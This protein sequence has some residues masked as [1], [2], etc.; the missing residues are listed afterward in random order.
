MG[1]I[2]DGIEY[3]TELEGYVTNL[4]NVNDNDFD[5]AQEILF[6]SVSGFRSTIFSTALDILTEGANHPQV[7][8]FA[9]SMLADSPFTAIGIMLSVENEGALQATVTG[10]TSAGITTAIGVTVISPIIASTGL[11]VAGAFAVGALA[12]GIVGYVVDNAVDGIYDYFEGKIT[13]L[14]YDDIS[15]KLIIDTTLENIEDVKTVVSPFVLSG[16][17]EENHHIDDITINQSTNDETFKYKIKKGDTVWDLCQKYGITED[18]LIAANPWLDERYSADRKF[19]LIRPDEQLLIP[20]GAMKGTDASNIIDKTSSTI[21]GDYYKTDMPIPSNMNVPTGGTTANPINY[22]Y[23]TKPNM[24]SNEELFFLAMKSGN[25]A[26]MEKFAKGIDKNTL[27]RLIFAAAN[28]PGLTPEMIN[29]INNP[30]A[31]LNGLNSTSPTINGID[32]L[33]QYFINNYQNGSVLP[34][35][36][37]AWLDVYGKIVPP[38]NNPMAIDLDGDGIETIDINNSQVYFDVDNDGFR[39]QTGWISGND[40]ILAIDR[41]Q[42]GKIDNQTEMFG[43]TS[44]TGFSDLRALDTNSDN[45]IDSNDTDFGKIRLW[46]DINEN[47]VTD[48][49]E[50]STLAEAGITSISLLSNQINT[51]DNNNYITEKAIVRYSDNSIKDLYDV[52]TQYNDRYTVYGGTYSL[53]VDV[54]DLPWLHGY[55][56]CIDLQLAASQNDSLKELISDMAVMTDANE[57]YNSFDNLLSKWIGENQTG[58]NLH[59]TVLSKLIGLDTSNMSEFQTNNITNAYNELKDKLFVNFFAQTSLADKFEINY[60]YKTDCLLY[61]DNIYENIVRNTADSDVFMA[62][63]VIAKMM[64]DNQSLDVTKLANAIIDVGY[65][66]H[67][68]N[69]INSG[70]KFVNDELQYV[71]GRKIKYVIGTSGNDTITGTNEADII[72]G[73]DGNDLINGGTG[74]DFLSGGRG[75][76]TLY[77]GDG[78]DTL[79]GGEGNDTLEGGGGDDTY[80]YNGQGNDTILDQRWATVMVQEWRQK[81]IFSPFKSH[82]V[83]SDKQELVDAGDD[84]VVFGKN[85]SIEDISISRSGNNLVFSQIGTNNTLTIKNWYVKSGKQRVERFQFQDGLTLNASHILNI[86]TDSGN[87]ANITINGTTNDDFILSANGND[88]I[89]GGAGKDIIVNQ[90]GNTT[91]HFGPG[92]GQDTIYDYA[93]NDTLILDFD[94][95]DV[96]YKRKGGDL[97]LKFKGY[98]DSL[99]VKD[100]FINEGNRIETIQVHEGS[101]TS[102]RVMEIVT[103]ASASNGNDILYGTSGNDSI[104]AYSGD[105]FISTG[106]GNDTIQGGLGNDIMMGGTG[107]DMYYVNDDGDQ[108]IEY[109]N[110]GTDWVA[111]TVSYELPD[112]IEKMSLVGT[113]AINGRGND[114][115]NII[116]GNSNNNIFDGKAGTNTLVGYGGDDTYIINVSNANDSIVE[117]ADNGNDTVKASITY[118]ISNKVNIENLELTGSDDIN[119]TGNSNNNYLIGNSGDNELRGLGGNDTL[120][121]GGGADTLYGGLGDDTYIIDNTTTTIVDGANQ[122]NDTV[123]SSINYTLGNNIENLTLSGTEDINGT[124]NALANVITGNDGDNLIEGKA[125]NDS[126]HGGLGNDTYVFNLGNGE[127]TIFETGSNSTYTDRIVFGSGITLDNLVFSKIGHDLVVSIK[128]TTDK[129]TIKD[130][131]INPDNRIEEFELYDG[132]IINGNDFY[133]LQTDL[134]HSAAYS[135][136]SPLEV[137]SVSASVDRSGY[138]EFNKDGYDVYYGD[139]HKPVEINNY[140]SYTQTFTYNNSGDL[141]YAYDGNYDW[142]YTYSTVNN[143]KVVTGSM[144][145]GSDL[146]LRQ[147]SYYNSNDNVSSVEVYYGNSNDVSKITNYIYDANQNVTQVL[148]YNV[149]YNNGIPTQVATLEKTNTYHADGSLNLSSTYLWHIKSDD[150]TRHKYLS[151]QELHTYNST[152]QKLQEQIYDGYFNEIVDNI[153]NE[154]TLEYVR[155]KNVISYSYNNS[156]QLSQV[157]ISSGYYNTATSSYDLHTS[158]STTYTYDD[159]GLLSVEVI[160]VGYQ[161]NNGSWATKVANRFE[162]TYNDSGLLVERRRYDYTLN[163]NGTYSRVLAEKIQNTYN[164][165]D[166]LEYTNTYNGTTLASSIKYEYVYDNDGNIVTEMISNGVI[167]NNEVQS[168]QTARELDIKAYINRLYGDNDNNMLVGGDKDD[169]I[170]GGNGS[171]TIYGG[172]GNDTIDGGNQIDLMFGGK[173][174]DTYIVGNTNDKIIENEDSGI[175]TVIS[176]PSYRL[177][178]NVENLILEGS[179]SSNGYGNDLNNIIK[180]NAQNNVLS[181]LGGNDYLEG[182]AGNDILYGGINDDTLI[183]G[184]GSDSLGGGSGSDTYLFGIGDGIDTIEEYSGKNDVVKF[185]DSVSRGN[186]A[187][188]QDNG[189]LIIDYGETSGINKFTI[190]DQFTTNSNKVVERIELDDGKYMTDADINALIQNMTAYATSNEIQLTSVDSVKNDTNLMNLVAAAWHN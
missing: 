56:N 67:L 91:Y 169:Y 31:V 9:G 30:E 139:N 161:T 27:V 190:K 2:I 159:T 142:Y 106:A 116:Y 135:D 174:N 157:L 55:G 92:H 111:T 66:A 80:I 49:G 185:D 83:V 19:A 134:E 8:K 186:I 152:G 98:S 179:M 69:Y 39:E 33:Q 76:D 14:K 70:L 88:T 101:L 164:E 123:I 127:D 29:A 148:G 90:S 136:F 51:L 129:I 167:S 22:Q 89:T 151:A 11:P 154:V 102:T 109:E 65:G 153:T 20:T 108:V 54:L 118:S 96:L 163:S 172:A 155:H 107:N 132:T 28:S 147:V 180:G 100:W 62:S 4:T 122:G 78:N 32:A 5:N 6:D 124:G 130:S 72:Y 18:E 7:L 168:Y 156:N 121:G 144:Y 99:T 26:Q 87:N 41:N 188:Y 73:M 82:W 175:D 53:D 48:S 17:V 113:A 12:T 63:Y 3:N 50:L 97:V 21:N 173:G 16:N 85:V 34:S 150:G 81:D 162:Y 23:T 46:Q 42:N 158:K 61:N 165:K 25:K 59:S 143:C 119:G 86:I 131:N 184:S 137:N 125:G 13:D 94:N 145:S 171:D 79:I 77:G 75:N 43:S 45:I 47:G 110:E 1:V 115:D 95:N 71:E 37:N 44:T 68:I 140:N 38:Q 166:K 181:G 84:V 74:D 40:A 183:G 103:S 133:T 52:A 105:D 117:T 128:N 112:N 93:G 126:L 187:I 176:T 182:G 160:T 170:N 120:Y 60:D 146:Y 36:P 178:D 57:M 64:V 35:N 10:I 58:T 104:S 138:S 15:K 114:L 141:T 149:T 177:P 189:D 24:L